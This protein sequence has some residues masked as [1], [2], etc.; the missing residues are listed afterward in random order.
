M[1]TARVARGLVF[2]EVRWRGG[3]SRGGGHVTV[4][5]GGSDGV[6]VGG[7]FGR[8]GG[9]LVVEGRCVLR[10]ALRSESVVSHVGVGDRPGGRRE[11]RLERGLKG[12]SVGGPG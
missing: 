9:S 4:A 1:D 12:G 5:M 10:R 6:G 2:V 7:G 3:D 11:R 8:G